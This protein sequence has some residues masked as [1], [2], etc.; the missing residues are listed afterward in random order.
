MVKGQLLRQFLRYDKINYN[1]YLCKNIIV[2]ILVIYEDGFAV[3]PCMPSINDLAME[4][5][6]NQIFFR[7]ILA[8][9]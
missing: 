5:A 8:V 1:A 4:C 9:T 6:S 7:E 3:S 2:F